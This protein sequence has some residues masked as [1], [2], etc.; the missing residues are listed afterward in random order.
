MASLNGGLRQEALWEA[1]VITEASSESYAGKLAVAEVLR[2]RGWSP[3]GFAG[4][5]RKDLSSFLL[6][7]PPSVRAEA[8]EAL[9]AARRGSNITG[10]ATHFENVEQFG[11]PGWAKRMETTAKIG[12]HTFFKVKSAG[13]GETATDARYNENKK[14]EK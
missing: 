7:Q 1:I 10:A 6:E 12:S 13:T 4:I 11:L 2:N 3:K 14:E 5:K 9:R 8:K